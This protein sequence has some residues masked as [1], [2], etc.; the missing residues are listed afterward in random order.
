MSRQT[1][2]IVIASA[3][4]ALSTFAQVV[5]QRITL[6]QS[7]GVV[8]ELTGSSKTSWTPSRADVVKFEKL[9]PA[10]VAASKYV[11]NTRIR[12]ELPDFKRQYF[13]TIQNGH[14][15]LHV[16]FFHKSSEAVRDGR[17]L[18]SFLQVMGGGDSFGHATFEL[19]S[20]RISEL[21]PNAPK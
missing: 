5:G 6:P 18:K 13:G 3:F 4:I 1:N 19:S 2:T 14:R 7:D 11:R 9:L 8:I 21:F 17:W 10:A 16:T 20:G 15:Q 12:R